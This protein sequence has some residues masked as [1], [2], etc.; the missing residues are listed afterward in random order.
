MNPFDLAKYPVAMQR[1]KVAAEETKKALST[2]EAVPSN[3]P[4]V[5]EGFARRPDLFG[6]I[7]RSFESIPLMHL[8][9]IK[10]DTYWDAIREAGL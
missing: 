9:F 10:D 7:Q 5:A 4:F 3:L 8:H 2:N 1:L 6:K